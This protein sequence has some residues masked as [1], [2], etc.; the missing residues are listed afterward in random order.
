M[1]QRALLVRHRIG[2][3]VYLSLSE[4]TARILHDAESRGAARH[5]LRKRLVWE[6]FGLLRH[7]R[8]DQLDTAATDM[9]RGETVK[10][11]IA[12]PD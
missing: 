1:V 3:K 11:V 7:Y 10:P 5:Q 12:F 9:H 8:L 2:T 4:R 6:G